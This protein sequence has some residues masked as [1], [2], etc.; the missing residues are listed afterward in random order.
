MPE[1]SLFEPWFEN[2]DLDDDVA[3]LNEIE[4][5]R[6]KAFDVLVDTVADHLVDLAVIEKM[7]G[8]SNTAHV[9]RNR[10]PQRKKDRSGDLGEVLATEYVDRKTVYKVPVKRLRYKDDR[11]SAMRGDDVLGF[12]EAKS[13]VHV[14]KVEAKSR[15]SLSAT[16][17]DEARKGLAK[18]K[19][20]PNPS[21]LA[22]VEYILR[23]EDRDEEAD[24]VRRLQCDTIRVAELRHMVFTLSGNDPTKHLQANKESVRKGVKL[25]LRGCR[26]SSHGEFVHDVFETCLNLGAGDG[27][28][29]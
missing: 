4:G 6:E 12:R 13:R 24:L 15:A 28:S 2:S 3:I 8:F 19:G 1:D 10:L 17:I 5:G 22:F 26:V 14:L 27:D 18:H 9:L 20:R 16:V 21:T 7:G 25:L 29:E 11:G 23:K